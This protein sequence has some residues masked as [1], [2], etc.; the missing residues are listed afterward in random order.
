MK[1]RCTVNRFTTTSD[2]GLGVTETSSE[3]TEIWANIKPMSAHKRLEFGKL[4]STITHEIYTWYRDNV[5][6][7]DTLTY[8]DRDFTLK[9]KINDDE[10]S[11]YTI[12][13][14]A[15]DL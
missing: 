2:G 13:A 15:E 11:V 12:F 5:T 9:T 10:E 3:L 14:A 8:N 1:Q 4:D 6:I 7:E